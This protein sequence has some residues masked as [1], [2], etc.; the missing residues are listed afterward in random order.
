VPTN[1]QRRQAAKRK[2]ERQL[3]RRAERAKRRRIWGVSVTVG[4]VI[5]AVGLVYWLVNLGPDDSQA[6][7]NDS[8]EE[9]S[10][11]TTDGPCAYAENPSEQPPKPVGT[12]DDPAETPNTGTVKVTL[13][14]N[15][16]D[17]PVELDRAKAPCTVQSLLH[18]TQEKFYD[19][20][21]CH[22]LT[23]SEGLKV[24]Q[25]GDPLGT[26]SGGPGYTVPDELDAAKALAPGA[27]TGQDGSPTVI[28]PRGVVA[29]ANGGPNT[30]GSQFF[31]VYGDSTLA[32]N[33][34]VV[35]TVDAAGLTVLD[36][37]AA[38]GVGAGGQS[39]EDGPPASPV[40]ITSAV[41]E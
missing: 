30:T 20:T 1:E 7:P 12:P 10:A 39:P 8:N 23:A 3:V 21:N 40:T 13:K 18:L 15:Q 14:T 34:T 31:L 35:G 41:A 2:L 17:I 33:Y 26:G 32:P 27:A 36:K 29:M 4:V 9:T 5:A 25:C 38:G 28:Y 16:G 6:A 11:N 24:L 37:I 19:N 22:R